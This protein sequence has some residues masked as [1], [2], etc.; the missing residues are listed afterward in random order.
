MNVPGSVMCW[1]WGML[2]MPGK[3]QPGSPLLGPFGPGT[4]S[5]REAPKLHI[6]VPRLWGGLRAAEQKVLSWAA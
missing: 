3:L 5:L 2:R 1:G 4:P 6:L